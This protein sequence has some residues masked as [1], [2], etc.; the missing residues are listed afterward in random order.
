MSDA[1]PILHMITPL[2]HTSPFDVNM[3]VD[4]GFH[5]ISSNVD[6]Q[7]K[8]VA[9]L[10]QDAMFSRSPDAA[11]RTVLFIG[12]KDASLALDQMK[13]A[14]SA[15]FPPFEI[16]IFADPAGSFTTAA[17]MIA[18]VEKGLRGKREGGLEGAKVQVYG[19]TGVVGGIAAVI[20]AQAGADVTIV[21]HRVIED[22]EVKA[23]DFKKRFGVKLNCAVAANDEEKKALV[24][25]A[26]VILTAAAAGVEVISTDVLKAATNLLV[27]ADINAVPPAG[28]A[29]VGANDDGIALPHGVGIGALVIGQVKYQVQHQILKRIRHS[30]TALH[31]GFAEAFELARQLS[32]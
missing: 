23:V 4:A 26:E 20:A 25:E 10:T 9:P 22:V 12:G 7:L 18:L 1:E 30:D 19:A 28:V 21:S 5:I 31:I 13:A 15:L 11:K 16:S 3:A 14:A 27:A 8:D 24:P 6:V 32:A 17:A 2:K 29:G